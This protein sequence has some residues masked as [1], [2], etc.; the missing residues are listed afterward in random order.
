MDNVAPRGGR[1]VACDLDGTLI[2]INSYQHWVV[3][4]CLFALI[5][6]RLA[7][8]KKAFVGFGGKA[9]GKVTR[10]QVKQSLIQAADS[11]PL[12][13]WASER[14]FQR[15]IRFFLRQDIL[16]RVRALRVGSGQRVF[17][18]TAAW[19]GYCGG[20]ATVYGLDGVLATGT[21]D[22]RENIGAEKVEALARAVGRDACLTVFTDHHDDLPLAKAAAA[23]FLVAPPPRSLAEFQRSGVVFSLI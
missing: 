11:S 22:M 1:V 17:V 14:L 19:E 7:F 6:L 3:F 10:W 23:V 20:L 5:T 9:R 15:Y 2:T 4:S 8:L 21:G 16:E 13:R 12:L 18:V